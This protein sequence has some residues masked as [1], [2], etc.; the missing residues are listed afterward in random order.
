M[1]KPFSISVDTCFEGWATKIDNII[2][3]QANDGY[4]LTNTIVVPYAV[5]TLSCKINSKIILVFE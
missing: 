4:R 5:F 2:S 1:T 3:Q